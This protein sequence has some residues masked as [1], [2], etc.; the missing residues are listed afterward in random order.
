MSVIKLKSNDLMQLDLLASTLCSPCLLPRA[1]LPACWASTAAAG[2]CR[3]SISASPV[4]QREVFPLPTV[5]V[6]ERAAADEGSRLAP[7]A[8]LRTLVG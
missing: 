3:N 1:C 5:L 2:S 4:V 8:V 7:A 6:R